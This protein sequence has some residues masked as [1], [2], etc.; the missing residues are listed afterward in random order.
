MIQLSYYHELLDGIFY[1]LDRYSVFRI[2]YRT[3]ARTDESGDSFILESVN[4]MNDPELFGLAL[5]KLITEVRARI[6][7]EMKFLPNRELP[8]FFEEVLDCY[9]DLKKLVMEPGRT[10]AAT[11]KAWGID[12]DVYLFQPQRV[13]RGDMPETLENIPVSVLSQAA[14]FAHTWFEQIDEAAARARAALAAL[15]IRTEEGNKPVFNAAF[16][17]TETKQGAS[18]ETGSGERVTG[19]KTSGREKIVL[20]CSVNRLGLH[21][22]LLYEEGFFQN[23]TKMDLCKIISK[24]ICTG[25]QADISYR[26]LKKAIDAPKEQAIRLFRE[27]WTDYLEKAE[28][29]LYIN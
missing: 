23:T 20:T 27:K 26:S 7:A 9:L 1:E 11:I 21:L 22:K 8:L 25:K 24:F 18:G 15:W 12:G 10:P 19:N 4:R 3:V 5:E 6:M 13:I 16:S 28:D 17:E 29:Q 2:I 14:D